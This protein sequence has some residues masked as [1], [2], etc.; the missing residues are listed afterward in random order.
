MGQLTALEHQPGV[1][2]DAHSAKNSG[3][4]LS[5]GALCVERMAE[6]LCKCE[7]SLLEEPWGID[8][9][10]LHSPL[11]PW[12]TCPPDVCGTCCLLAQNLSRELETLETGDWFLRWSV[13][14][15]ETALGLCS[16]L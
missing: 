14:A 16:A 13:P 6:Q 3:P 8:P 11:P 1:G 12:E 10:R 5:S 9:S 4:L 2:L 7:G 15:L